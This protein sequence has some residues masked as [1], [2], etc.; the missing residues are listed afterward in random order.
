M[1]KLLGIILGISLFIVLGFTT[2]P[3]KNCSILHEGTFTYGS[4]E[5]LVTVEIKGENHLE[6][7]KGGKYFIKSKIKWVND[8]EYNMTMT[9]VTI[10]N[11]PYKPGDVMNV[12]INKVEKNEIFYTS[13]VN[14]KNWPGKF[15]KVK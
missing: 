3:D 4:G 15:T 6:N 7:H 8:C 5:D 13:T 1:K 12:V 10:P 2:H 9:E 11:F 14:G